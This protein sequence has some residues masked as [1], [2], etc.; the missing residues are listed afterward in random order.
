M[1]VN[2]FQEL[3]YHYGHEITV[4]MYGQDNVTLECNDCNEILLDFDEGE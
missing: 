2:S 4:A 3:Y 1:S